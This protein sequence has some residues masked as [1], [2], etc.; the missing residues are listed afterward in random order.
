MELAE[1]VEGN[2]IGASQSDEQ[3]R[4]ALRWWRTKQLEE[5]HGVCGLDSAIRVHVGIV[6]IGHSVAM[7]C[8]NEG[9]EIIHV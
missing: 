1:R 3:N 9:V 8:S 2:A 7:N 6:A 5:G 4:R